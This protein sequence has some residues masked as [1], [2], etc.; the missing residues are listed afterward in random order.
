SWPPLERC[1]EQLSRTAL[2]YT[3]SK[4]GASAD[5]IA[6]RSPSGSFDEPARNAVWKPSVYRLAMTISPLNVRIVSVA[7]PSP[8]TAC[9]ARPGP[10]RRRSSRDDGP[11]VT[12]KSERTDPLKLSAFN[13]KPEGLARVSRIVPEC[14]VRL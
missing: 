3:V 4:R 1:P 12:A 2:D 5:E 6:S 11:S 7:P 14:D 8:N 10:A 9:I 13:S